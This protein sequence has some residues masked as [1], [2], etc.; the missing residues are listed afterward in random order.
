MANK[1]KKK[2][3]VIKWIDHYSDSSWKTKKEIEKWATSPTF[4][5][6]RGEITYENDKV[7]VLSA[8]FDGDESY[9]ENICILKV[10]IVK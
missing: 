2:Y 8:S 9:G 5:V 3:Q 7:I 10:N 1:H 4:C 6:S